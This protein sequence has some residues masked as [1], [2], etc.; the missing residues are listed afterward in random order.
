M[1]KKLLL[2]TLLFPLLGGCASSYTYEP[3]VPYPE[4]DDANEPTEGEEP[5]EELPMMVYFYLDY[6]HSDDPT[7]DIKN[8]DGS[9]EVV[10]EYICSL[11]WVMLKPLGECPAEAILTD[12]DAADPL[13]PHFLGYSQYPTCLDSSKLWDFKTDYYQS[14]ILN[15]YGIWV[16]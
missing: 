9:V 7:N 12:A 1:K 5:V 14:N 15:L 11:S 16:A 13:Y 10:P 6:S 2:L 3:R 4:E 8:P